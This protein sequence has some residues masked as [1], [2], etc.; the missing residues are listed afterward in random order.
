MNSTK[1]LALAICGLVLM[2]ALQAGEVLYNGIELPD[3]WPPQPEQFP[4]AAGSL[5]PYLLE[6]PAIIPIDTGRQLF[7]D[8]FLIET[9]TLRREFHLP[10]LHAGNPILK[11][12]HP[13]IEIGGIDI[14]NAAPFSDG[15]WWDPADQLFKMWYYARN[16]AFTCYATSSDGITWDRPALPDSEIRDGNIVVSSRGDSSTTWL[17][18]QTSDP[19]RRFKMLTW[20]ANHLH[21]RVSGD[22]V[23]WGDPLWSSERG[24]GDRSTFFYNPFRRVWVYS[25]RKTDRYAGRVRVYLETRDMSQKPKL[26]DASKWIRADELDRVQDVINEGTYPDLYNVDATPYESLMLGLFS[27]HSVEHNQY[28]DDASH[29]KVVHVSLGFSR[30]GFH[31]TRPDRR[32]FLDIAHQG[33]SAWNRGNVQSVGGGCLLVGDRLYFYYSGRN[34]GKELDDASGMATGLAFLRRDGFA[35]M[36][37]DSSGGVLTT[38]PVVFNGGHLFV[39]V[40]NPNGELT[41]AVLSED[42]RVLTPFSTAR[43]TPIACDSTI[44]R[45]SWGDTDLSQLAGRTVRF[46]FRLRDGALYSFWVSPEPTGASHGFVAAGG[47]G[48]TSDRDTVGLGDDADVETP[49]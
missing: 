3:A 13:A 48:F 22:G 2:S 12:E 8:D 47:P 11:P 7:V 32:P 23:T 43:C 20:R 38:R 25:I 30:D 1:T 35:S 37:A 17:D 45:V 26:D 10:T 14:P 49:R 5:P 41:V 42:G 4:R 33:A 21:F 39:N 31:W 46:Q 44:Q 16:G 24:A 29:P 19:A 9:T 40:D 15:V 34:S 27:I 18:S 28:P 36:N 6:P